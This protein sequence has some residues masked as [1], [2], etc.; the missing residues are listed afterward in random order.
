MV[1]AGFAPWPP[2]SRHLPPDRSTRQRVLRHCSPVT[3]EPAYQSIT[4]NVSIYVLVGMVIERH[5]GLCR[6]SV[7]N[8][9]PD[10]ICGRDASLLATT[11]ARHPA[12]WQASV[13]C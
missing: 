1:V 5:R 12:P 13:A 10:C 7:G 8:L 9:R 2:G 11:R 6:A 3:A 4:V